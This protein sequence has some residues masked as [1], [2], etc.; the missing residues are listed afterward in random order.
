LKWFITGGS[1]IK[2][3]MDSAAGVR[4]ATVHGSKGLEA[5][6]VFLIETI[7]TPKDKPEKIS[8]TRG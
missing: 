5:P 6:V 1:E 7:R 2:R 4:I 8:S 3:D